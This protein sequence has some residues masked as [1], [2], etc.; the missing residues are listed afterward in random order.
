M[1]YWSN[2]YKLL[3]ISLIINTGDLFLHVIIKYQLNIADQ[4]FPSWVQFSLQLWNWRSGQTLGPQNSVVY[5]RTTVRIKS[6]I[7]CPKIWRDPQSYADDNYCFLCNSFQF[8]HFKHPSPRRLL[9]NRM[10]SLCLVP[11]LIRIF[12]HSTRRYHMKKKFRSFRCKLELDQLY[13]PKRVEFP[14][15]WFSPN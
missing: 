15:P 12:H 3:S 8:F 2:Y 13:H 7:S 10:G 6:T 14:C 5:L 11:E 1:W 9:P 4:L